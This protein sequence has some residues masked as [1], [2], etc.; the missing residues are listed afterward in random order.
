MSDEETSAAEE[1]SQQQQQYDWSAFKDDE[2]RV[3]YYN[4]ATGESS[5]DAPEEGFNPPPDD[6]DG[7]V[8]QVKQEENEHTHEEGNADVQEEPNDDSE[9]Q[10][11]QEED[12]PAQVEEAAEPDAAATAEGDEEDPPMAGDWVEY[13]D[14]EGRFYYFNAVSQETTWDRPP[15]FDAVAQEELIKQ[16]PMEEQDG[17]SPDRPQSPPMGEM[18]PESPAEDVPMKDDEEEQVQV[19]EVDPAVKR[20][21]DAKLALSQ[22]DAIME[23]GTTWLLFEKCKCGK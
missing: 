11:P 3:Y 15:E 1:G 13:K 19:E 20:L 4:N 9:E 22:P 14:D 6:D 7:E 23:D 10:Q 16:E 12:Q 8:E 5:W 21:E 18:A 2:G 17:V